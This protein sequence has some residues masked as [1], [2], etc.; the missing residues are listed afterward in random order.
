[1]REIVKK[2]SGLKLSLELR[3]HGTNIATFIALI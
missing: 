2:N 1:M 3:L